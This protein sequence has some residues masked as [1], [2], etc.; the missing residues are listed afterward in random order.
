MLP[1]KMTSQ[2]GGGRVYHSLSDFPCYGVGELS[3]DVKVVPQLPSGKVSA[4][5]SSVKTCVV[6][7]LFFR[8]GLRSDCVFRCWLQFGERLELVLGRSLGRNVAVLAYGC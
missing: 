1:G 5:M 2:V 4:W 7:C 8:L 3:F 6:S